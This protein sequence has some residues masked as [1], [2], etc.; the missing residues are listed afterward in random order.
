MTL[1]PK[2]LRFVVEAL[3]YYLD[4]HDQRF[5]NPNASEDD[6][7]DW[8]NDREFIEAILQDCLDHLSQPAEQIQVEA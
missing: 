3:N 5:R 4:E 2:A 7:A 6:R 8:E 1:S